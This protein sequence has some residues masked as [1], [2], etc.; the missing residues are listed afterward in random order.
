MAYENHTKEQLEEKYQVI[1]TELEKLGNEYKLTSSFT[2][3][4]QL[5]EEI[6]ECYAELGYIAKLLGYHPV[7]ES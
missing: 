6:Y 7:K 1:V 2:E 5:G 3:K 4:E